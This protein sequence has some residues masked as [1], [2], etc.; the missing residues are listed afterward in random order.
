VTVSLIGSSLPTSI[1]SL[2]QDN[3]LLRQ[4]QDAAFPKLLYRSE[5]VPHKWEA[6]IGERKVFTRAGLIR[7]LTTPLAPGVDPTPRSYD[8]EQWTAEARQY[9]DTIDTHM[10]S[11]NVALAN[12]YLRNTQQLGMNAGQ[13]INRVARNALFLNYLA[14]ETTTTAVA[15][16]SATSIAV[17]SVVGFSEVLQNGRISPVSATNPLPITFTTVAAPANTVI[18]V[19]LND[20]L[21]PNGPGTLFLGTALT[22]GIALRDAVLAGTRSERLRVGGGNTVD[23]L[24]S[25][26]ILTVDSIISAVSRLRQNNIMPHPDG[27]YHVHLEPESE[28]EIFRD[29]QWQSLY[30]SLPDSFAYRELA[31]GQIVGSVCYRNTESPSIAT[32]EATVALPG[33]AGGALLATDIGKEVRNASS[34]NIRRTI[35]TGGGALF[36]EYIDESNYITDA[37]IT[38]KIGSFSI[39]NAGASVMTDRIRFVAR[40]P[41][42]RLQQVLGQSWSWSGDFAVPSDALTG[43]SARFKR[44]VVIEHA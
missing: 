7:P 12:L 15:A 28:A 17:S 13:T 26:N 33:G 22:V 20:P 1:S 21:V 35:V 27:Y 43:S 6:D 37:G 29:A 23:A 24:T 36:E 30:R 41:L 3:T 19:A 31:I 8:T 14:G 38:G 25:A 40:A 42:D 10:P 4:F 39:T 9:A 16:I 5:A 44:A 2:I 32:V 18:G 11:S 34:V